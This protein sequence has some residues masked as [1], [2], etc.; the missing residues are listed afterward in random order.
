MEVQRGSD[1]DTPSSTITLIPKFKASSHLLWLYSPV[2]SDLA[3]ASR[4][5]LSPDVAHSFSGFNS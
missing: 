2:E 4:D 1:G 5:M 3:G